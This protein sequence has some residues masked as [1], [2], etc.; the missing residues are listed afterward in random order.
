MTVD[1]SPP[2]GDAPVVAMRGLGKRYGD[3]AALQDLH[4]TVPARTIV[5]FLGPNGAG[6]T[7]AMKLLVGLAR[8]STGSAEVFGLDVT[9]HGPAIRSRLGYLAQE[10]RFY[11]HLSA[12]ETLRFVGRFFYDGPEQALAR[13]IDDLLDFVGLVDKADRPIRGFSGGERQRLGIAQANVND[14]E[15]LLMDE[16]AASLDPAGRQ[17][18]LAI[19]ERLRE[20]TT[21]FFSTH[22]LDDVERVADRVAIL[23]R[24]RLLAH[25]P[26]TELLAGDGESTFSLRLRG[27]HRSVVDRLERQPWVERVE[28]RPDAGEQLLQVQVRDVGAAE[29]QLLRLALAE[30]EVIVSSYGRRSFELEDVFLRLVEGAR[31]RT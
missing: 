5:G 25:A 12:R 7:T 2:P 20:R 24:G 28:S 1:A 9:T 13:R 18:V 10:P 14:P 6:K 15:L 21:V 26:T 8:P 17:A 3:V 16:P 22:I 11:E 19:L 23:D 29:T 27:P 30:P 4:L 31:E